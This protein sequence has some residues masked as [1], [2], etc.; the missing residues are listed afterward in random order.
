MT[1]QTP[2]VFDE[3]H[4]NIFVRQAAS[5]YIKVYF[6]SSSVS[7][8]HFL[9]LFTAGF[10]TRFLSLLYIALL[11]ESQNIAPIT[12]RLFNL[13]LFFS[14]AFFVMRFPPMQSNGV[15]SY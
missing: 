9:F 14:S 1:V 15:Q 2:R 12:L 5:L 13:V 11:M 3:A 8:F 10:L 6:L 7:S 4:Q